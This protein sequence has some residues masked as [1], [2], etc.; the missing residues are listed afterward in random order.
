MQT[1]RI[2]ATILATLTAVALVATTAPGEVVKTFVVN[3]YFGVRYDNEPVSTDVTFAKP[4][5]VGA[6]AL[7]DQPYQVEIL[8]GTPE[9]VRKARVWTAVTFRPNTWSLQPD[10]VKD[11]AALVKL[12]REGLSAEG[13][14]AAKQ[15]WDAIRKSMRLDRN[16]KGLPEGCLSDEQFD[17]LRSG[18]NAF[19]QRN[20]RY[21]DALAKRLGLTKDARLW[22]QFN[23]RRP[24]GE[25]VGQINRAAVEA[26]WGKAVSA[27]KVY[28]RQYVFK[29]V[30]QE[31]RRTRQDIA[32]KTGDGGMVGRVP[33][34]I[35]DNGMFRC[36]V[37]W[38]GVEYTTPVQVFDVPGP[39]VSVSRDGTKWIGSGYLD[40]MLRVKKLEVRTDE[41]PIYTEVRMVYHF[42]NDRTYK[43]RARL[44][45]HKPYVQLV[46]DFDL[47]GASKYV[48]NYDDWNAGSFL[49]PGDARLVSWDSLR[50]GNPCGD[51]VEIEGQKALARLAIWSQFNY[52]AGK[53]ETIA[54]KEPDPSALKERYAAQR[55]K[56]A[57]EMEKY[58]RRVASGWK[59]RRG[60]GPREPKK[61][62]QP[63]YEQTPY[64]LAG[65][66]AKLGNVSTPPGEAMAVGAFYIRPD[67]WTRAKVNHVDL[68]MRPEV[69]GNRM[70]R[71]VVG[72]KGA[73]LRTAM[74]AWLVDGHR[75]WAIF[76]VP[77]ADDHFFAKAHVLE[78]VWPLDRLNRLT[79][80]WNSDGSPVKPEH[81]KPPLA[82]AGGAAGPV[83]KG[84][85]GRS[86]L[87][88]FNGSNGHIR[89]GYPPRDG[90]DGTVEPTYAKDAD[91]NRMVSLAITAYMASDDSAYPSFR[92]MLPWTHPEAI[93][94]F[95][96]GMENMNFNADLYRYV[97]SRAYPLAKMGHPEAGRFL[98]HAEKSFDMALDRY[99]YPQSGCWEESHGYAGHTLKVVGPL[100][101]AMANTK[102][103]H[104]FLNDPRLARMVEF[105]LYV[106]SPVDA[107]FGNRVVP[108]V[109]D[110]GQS[111]A[112][113][114][115][116]LGK[117]VGFFGGSTH[118]Q[119]RRIVARAAWLMQEDNGAV[120]DGVKPQPYD[121]R[122]RWLQ[123]YGTVLRGLGDATETLAITLDRAA[124]RAGKKRKNKPREMSY[125]PLMVT[126]PLDT[127]GR[128]VK[129]L[130]GGAPRHNRGTV[131]GTATLQKTDGGLTVELD[132]ELSSDKWVKG[133]KGRYTVKLTPNGEGVYGG[134]TAGRFDGH[135]TTGDASARVGK[136]NEESFL[137]L[138][139]GQ[140]WG[141]HH[142]DKGSMWFW[143]R[144]VH[145]F[146]DCS[147]GSPPGGTYGNPFK[148]GPASGTQI[149]L[150]GI[151]NWI[152]P[153]KYAAPYIADEDYNAAA[154]YDY[155]LARCQFPFNP[156]LDV[157]KGTP[158]AL[159][160]GYDRQVLFVH[161]D[162]LIVRDNV[163][164]N[165]PAVWR[166]H[167]YQKDSTQ[168]RGA[169]A[170]LKSPQ[171]VTGELAVVYPEKVKLDALGKYPAVNPW[172][173][174]P[175]GDSGKP[176]KSLMLRWDMP[177]GESATWVFAVHGKDQ[178]AAKTQRLDE[179]G[180]V[181][182]VALAD[183]T[184]IVA[185]LNGKPFEHTAWGRTFRGTAGLLVRRDGKVT[186]HAIRGKFS[187]K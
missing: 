133:G 109:G 39:V 92:A 129:I 165:C 122:S 136:R 87:Q 147:W 159:W 8:E 73:T 127:S 156:K 112:G 67:R 52:F 61:P 77:A 74:E 115:D 29:V 149:E 90:W 173:G 105:F 78:G 166:L 168:V 110:H 117:M 10:E 185:F 97:S 101:Q 16:A 68:Y 96:Q 180:H 125:V 146:G 187:E 51:F 108:A 36:K 177:A 175:H 111:K 107:E 140:S 124:V 58:R 64:T 50:Q 123:G 25:V 6:I 24:S 59:D 83:L 137:V 106:H 174:R 55:Q 128:Q 94:P 100:A 167:S 176:F 113:P 155:A 1:R 42:E 119:V 132:L 54:L 37:P 82:D 95:Y 93:N 179:A 56:Y 66:S 162:V 91:I 138:R 57:E 80:V 98:T 35:L 11:P 2:Y 62:E 71:G 53:Q 7:K 18:I 184:E 103:R 181:T 27:H 131:S 12:I 31:P 3:E 65:T 121:L 160:N 145:F 164:T 43:V 158:V 22:E 116:R 13:E 28:P 142:M 144:N 143:G 120:P 4:V 153:C 163:E 126:V 151:T 14:T 60:R 118:P 141:H 32:V 170:T 21:P 69:P 9:A 46:E 148:Q 169:T 134:S 102:G 79:L 178:E 44:Y 99:V 171:G 114:A 89:G 150:R 81:Q 38:V 186:A 161:P 84:T 139:A 15:A 183:G 34:A 5:M 157:N 26:A 41:G 49:N 172:S 182:K 48:F 63:A 104:N 85:R 152:L 23:Q 72:L 40:S 135:E 154:G 30:L 47:G 20:R 33:L 75:E 19:I 130:G 17:E 88:Y 70:T 76:A 45:A 86:G